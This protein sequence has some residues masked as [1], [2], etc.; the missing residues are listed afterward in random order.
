[1]GETSRISI[2]VAVETGQDTVQAGDVA[3]VDEL[4]PAVEI[5]LVRLA[6]HAVL[7]GGRGCARSS[8]ASP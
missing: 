2:G 8:A 7:R 3:A 4:P 5:P 1:M 6:G